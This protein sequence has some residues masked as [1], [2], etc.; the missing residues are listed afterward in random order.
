MTHPTDPD[1]QTLAAEIVAG[2]ADWRA[3][4]P[5]A[6]FRAIEA[7]VE[8]R[9]ARLRASML[10]AAAQQSAALEWQDHPP[11]QQPHCPACHLPLQQRGLQ[12]RTLRSQH[13]QPV[14]L[15]RQYGTCPQCGDG[16]FPP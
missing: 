3:Q 6:P 16:F 15:T 9:L 2:L 1:L 11:A 14:T 4:H 13:N 8:S 10:T 5:T 7:E 12:A